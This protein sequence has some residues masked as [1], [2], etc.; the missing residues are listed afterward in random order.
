MLKFLE[1]YYLNPIF[2]YIVSFM[3]CF[4]LTGFDTSNIAGL[5]VWAIVGMIPISI[6]LGAIMGFLL[7]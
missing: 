5:M 4:I 6:I 2:I 1:K 7:F 3:V